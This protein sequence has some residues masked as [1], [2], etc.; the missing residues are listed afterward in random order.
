LKFLI[1]GGIFTGEGAAAL[2]AGLLFKFDA[3]LIGSMPYSE[4]SAA[5]FNMFAWPF[6]IVGI[7][8]LPI[9][10]SFLIA[11][12]SKRKAWMAENTSG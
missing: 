1:L 5:L 3:A 8:S 7:I 4:S 12:A 10:L 11:G 6:I 9:G 2:M